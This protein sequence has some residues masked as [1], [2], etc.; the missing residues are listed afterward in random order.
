M[1]EDTDA[2]R[3]TRNLRGRD[4]GWKC[5]PSRAEMLLDEMEKSRSARRDIEVDAMST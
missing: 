4:R 3:R 1:W 2:A 5:S